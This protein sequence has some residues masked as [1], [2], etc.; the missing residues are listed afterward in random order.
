MST[1][2]QSRR[3]AEEA[4]AAMFELLQKPSCENCW[5]ESLRKGEKCTLLRHAGLDRKLR[6]KPWDL[7][8]H[9]HR[10]RILDAAL[11]ASKW[12]SQLIVFIEVTPNE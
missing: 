5:W 10:K 2:E 9:S 3:I 1:D 4:L 11:R 6:S 7:I 12:A 8:P